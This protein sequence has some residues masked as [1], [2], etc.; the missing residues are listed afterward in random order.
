MA[1]AMVLVG[2]LAGC[3]DKSP[4]AASIK[5]K[6]QYADGKPVMEMVL[7]FHPLD[8]TNKNTRPVLFTDKQGN[9]SG[10]GVKGRYKVTLAALPKGSV[11]GGAGGPSGGFTPGPETGPKTVY[12]DPQKTPWL[13]DVP[14]TGKEDIVLTVKVQ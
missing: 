4:E 1:A 7:T 10:S 8:E 9:F 2:I 3:K 6:V 14:E 11:G 13:V 12:Q 5:G